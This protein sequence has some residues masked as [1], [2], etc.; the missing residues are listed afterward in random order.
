MTTTIASGLVYTFKFVAI[1]SIGTSPDSD[2]L[3]VVLARP[4]S[5][6]AAPGFNILKSNRTSITV[7]WSMGVSLDTPVTGYRLY[8]DL[9]LN[10][11]YSLIYDGDGNI[12]KL[13]FTH[14]G[15]TTGLVYYYKLEVLNFNGPSDLSPSNFRAS[16]DQPSQFT[17]VN[18]KS[19]S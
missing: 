9:G 8:S 18:L 14:T 2:L 10:G 1:N 16:C 4:P 19:T 3:K 11:D 13:S 12:N 7:T 15:L 6:P 5:T 17:S